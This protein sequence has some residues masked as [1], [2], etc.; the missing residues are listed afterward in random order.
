MGDQSSVEVDAVVKNT[1]KSQRRRNGGPPPILYN[2]LL[3]PTKVYT[4]LF[5]SDY[6]CV[7]LFSYTVLCTVCAFTMECLSACLVILGYL[8][9][10]CNQV[11]V[12]IKVVEGWLARTGIH[13]QG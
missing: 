10:L 2:M 1:I 12:A 8:Y 6:L 7:Y 3:G 11:N 4:A 13:N 5:T 9:R